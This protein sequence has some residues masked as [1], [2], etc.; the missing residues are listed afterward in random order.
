M[1][2]RLSESIS[3]LNRT[4]IERNVLFLG[5]FLN[6][7]RTRLRGGGHPKLRGADYGEMITSPKP[8]L[9]EKLSVGHHLRRLYEIHA[10]QFQYCLMVL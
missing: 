9:R 4:E 8:T 1:Y 6:G 3:G 2:T 5:K 7:R 10:H